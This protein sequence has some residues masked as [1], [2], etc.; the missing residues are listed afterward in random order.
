[1]SKHIP[2]ASKLE[3]PVTYSSRDLAIIF[4]KQIKRLEELGFIGKLSLG[5]HDRLLALESKVAAINPLEVDEHMPFV[6][7]I[8][9]TVIPLGVQLGL[10]GTYSFLPAN[11]MFDREDTPELTEPYLIADLSLG[12][13]T[14]SLSSDAARAKIKSKRRQALDIYETI[15][16]IIHNPVMSDTVR[17]LHAARTLHRS[18]GEE[19]V[20]DLYRFA[21]MLKVKRDNGDKNDPQWVTPSFKNRVV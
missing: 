13:D 16:L 12:K 18:E 8:P 3:P 9:E 10:V 4:S 2:G 15:A 1:M 5:S 20:I 17:G 6:V 11:E 14:A 7:V 21:D 19:T